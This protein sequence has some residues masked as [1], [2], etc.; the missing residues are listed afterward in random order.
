MRKDTRFK[1]TLGIFTLALATLLAAQPPGWWSSSSNPVV[2]PNATTSGVDQNYAPANLGQLKFIAKQ[3]KLHLDANLNGGSGS[4]INSLVSG[5]T[6]QQGVS[7]TQAELDALRAANYA[8]I[9]LGQ[10]KAVAKPFY[11]RLGAVGYDTKANLIAHG[12][13]A[14]WAYVYPWDPATP[15]A[16]NYAPANIGQLKMAFSFSLTGFDS[17]QDGLPDAWELAHGFDPTDSADGAVT[18]DADGDGLSNLDEFQQNSN[19][20]DYYSQGSQ[21]ITPV[22]SLS[23]GN[24]QSADAG[25]FLPDPIKVTVT[26]A[27]GGAPL[28]GAPVSFTA[29]TGAGGLASEASSYSAD[30]T[31]TIPTDSSGIAT[32]YWK[33]GANPGF[34]QV[35]AQSGSASAVTFSATSLPADGLWG[36]WRFFEGTGATASDTSG[37]GHPGTL[38]NSPAWVAGQNADGAL[39]FSG[40]AT[41]GGTKDFVTMGN[42][43]D[44]S[45]DFGQDSF[46][47]AVWVKFTTAAIAP[48][49]YGR[50]IVSKGHHGWN[51]GYCLGINPNGSFFAGVGTTLSGQGTQCVFVWTQGAF[52]DGQWH[53]LAAVFDRA[54]STAR[55]LVDGVRQ[56]IVNDA[57]AGGAVVDSKLLD[58]SALQHLSATRTDM[59]LTIGSHMG[60]YDFYKGELDDVRLYRRALSD[61][62][63]VAICG[64][65]GLLKAVAQTVSIQ[66]DTVATIS[67]KSTGGADTV[68]TSYEIVTQPANGEAVLDGSTIKYYPQA[69]FNGSDGLTFRAVNGSQIAEA[70]VSLNIEPDDDP[71]LV[72]VGGGRTVTLPDTLPLSATVTDID[73]PS[74]DITLSWL[75][76]SGE[77]EVIFSDTSIL[78][79]TASFSE[80]GEYVLRLIAKDGK[81]LRSDSLLVVVN[82]VGTSSAISGFS[83]VQPTENQ[84]FTLNQPVSIS[85]LASVS[86]G[87]TVTAVEFYEGS[88]KIGE[89]TVPGTTGNYEISWTP[90]RLGV[91]RLS[92]KVLT[93][94]GISA[95]STNSAQVRVVDGTWYSDPTIQAGNEGYSGTG[96]GGGLVQNTATG[97]TSGN[98]KAGDDG[99]GNPKNTKPSE[100]DSDGDGLTDDIEKLLGTIAVGKDGLDSDSDGVNDYDDAVPTVKEMTVRAAPRSSYAVIDL[101][102][103][104]ATSSNA[105]FPIQGVNDRGEVLLVQPSGTN[106]SSAYQ[107]IGMSYAQWH[108]LPDADLVLQL[109]LW[110][111]GMKLA[112]GES[113]WFAGPLNDGRVLYLDQAFTLIPS[114]QQGIFRY[115]IKS[116]LDGV[117]SDSGVGS[118]SPGFSSEFEVLWII[119]AP[120]DPHPPLALWPASISQTYKD[121]LTEMEDAFIALSY[122][123]ENHP[124]TKYAMAGAVTAANDAGKRMLIGGE[125]TEYGS[126]PGFTA[127]ICG[128]RDGAS[129]TTGGVVGTFWKVYSANQKKTGGTGNAIRNFLVNNSG[130]S[131][132]EESVETNWNGNTN[133][134][135]SYVVKANGIAVPNSQI[136]YDLNNSATEESPYLLGKTSDS[137]AIWCYNEGKY[138]QI[139][140]NGVVEPVG[141]TV[142]RMLSNS[143]VVPLGDKIWRNSMTHPVGD[144]CPGATEW[145]GW[146][147]RTVSPEKNLLAGLAIRNGKQHGVMLVPVDIAVDANRDGVIKFAGNFSDPSTDGKPA[148]TTTEAEPFRFWLNDDDDR[149]EVDHPG[150]STKDSADNEINS[151]RDLEDFTRLHL[152]IGGLQE[153]VVDGTLQVGLEWKKISAGSPSIKAYR[154]EEPSGGLKYIT[155]ENGDGTGNQYSATL[156]Q[157]TPF[158]IALGTVDRNGGLK[159]PASFWQSTASGIPA[160]SK[161]HS[162]RYLIFEGVTAGK[163][164]LVLTF[165]KDGKKIGESGGVWIDLKNIKEMYVRGKGAPETNQGHPWDNPRLETSYV[166]DPNG[167]AFEKPV[168]EEK[169][170]LVFVHGIHPPFTNTNDA[171]LGNINVAETT[172]KRLWQCGYKGRFAIYKWPA[173][174]PADYSILTSWN[175]TNIIQS[176]FNESEWRGYQYGKG[177]YNFVADQPMDYQRHIFSHSQGNAV[178]AAAFCDYAMPAKTW[179]VTQGAI[180]ISCYDSDI[181]HYTINYSSPSPDTAQEGG[182]RGWLDQAVSARVVNFYNEQDRVTGAVWE[183]NH[184]MVKPN[185]RDLGLYTFQYRIV[186]GQRKV[187]K[188][189]LGGDPTLWSRDVTELEES[190]SMLVQSRSR[191][192]AHGPNVHG[193]VDESIDLHNEFGFDNE[194][195]SQWERD[196]QNGVW[197]YYKRLLDEIN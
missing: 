192:I 183:A 13:P 54:T 82:P 15:V 165:W 184:S 28:V 40:A 127:F 35:S 34:Q 105:Y 45:L 37:F 6:P 92:A 137:A 36:H 130:F 122:N 145:S 58:F 8:P 131:A 163:G 169:T 62:E 196:I 150:S 52:N 152:Y 182:Y 11:D 128:W 177:L 88:R 17:D 133:N 179:I 73:T 144:L 85:A 68:A 61:E 72:S 186:S 191:A 139:K 94:T 138:S 87:T 126:S 153:A 181:S 190:M 89:S 118:E 10:L 149:G 18:A 148:D 155:N 77:G 31:I 161:D 136:L 3:A 167:F 185:R 56:D 125:S 103:I 4:A 42:P 76:V 106:T 65:T 164:Q 187:E 170:V 7:Y 60:Q 43:A 44:R 159:F 1:L 24:N 75:K 129:A 109:S 70:A 69:H 147:I 132:F 32:A 67:L 107:Y 168:D 33:L 53:H 90:P 134:A 171:Y 78:N 157:A 55:I 188:Y 141:N 111:G 98:D 178:V 50:R 102:E 175:L 49:Q 19:P 2:D 22:V 123:S 110:K 46:T 16:E 101:G 189:L 172:F 176:D 83:L 114:A 156:Q 47:M 71:P 113:I 51:A 116:W 23:A 20:H 119:A 174:T 95:F 146:N 81:S 84:S 140:I 14:T 151:I 91:Y 195:G 12:Y 121:T 57:L 173:L 48:G 154:A 30:T 29:A 117:S 97:P 180:P 100:L 64:Q 86:P 124:Y 21:T 143:L 63:I 160:F 135:A 197:G 5:F 80:P 194:H 74:E 41:E 38:S 27:D 158:K 142:N 162:T 193:E 39:S 104:P 120:F 99:K 96:G 108:G 25:S 166:Q 9:N 115:N 66:E 112:V 79:P 59:P 93:S 26:N